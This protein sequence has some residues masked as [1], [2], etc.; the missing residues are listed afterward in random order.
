MK[1]LLMSGYGAIDRCVTLGKISTPIL[2][3]TD[4]LIDVHAASINPIDY[5]LVKGALRAIQKLN[6]PVVLGF[7]VSGIVVAVGDR[8]R[9][10]KIGDAVYGRSERKRLGTFA[11]L[12]ALDESW[13]APMPTS[14]SFIEAASLPLVGLTTVQGLRDRANARSAQ[15]VL[16]HAGSGGVG[17]FAIQYAKALGLHVTTTTSS[18]NSKFVS[19]LGADKIICY[20]QEDYRQL[21]DRYDIVFDTLGGH[22]TIDAFSVTARGGTV[23]SVVG[24]PDK[25]FANQV[26]A[27]LLVRMAMHFMSRRVFRAADRAAAAYYRFLT[28]SKGSQLTEIASMVDSAKIKPV[29]DKVFPVIDIVDAMTYSAQ[30]R[31]RGKV[32]VQVK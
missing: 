10:F 16:I 7:D 29:I 2:T 14:T 6:F 19:S 1:A 21:K 5:K 26:D 24:P 18:R 15:K 20:D 4:V 12:A 31:T 11:E 22:H 30:G 32:V 3:A 28:E 9:Q 25:Q 8:V 23:I 13:V 17:T 27:G